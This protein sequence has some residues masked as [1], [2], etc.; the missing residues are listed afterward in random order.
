MGETIAIST[1]ALGFGGYFNTLFDT[2]VLL[3][4]ITLI[5]FFGLVLFTGVKLSVRFANIMTLTRVWG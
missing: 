3:V 5:L 2:S 4:S 1:V